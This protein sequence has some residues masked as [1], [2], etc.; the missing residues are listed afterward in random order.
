MRHEAASSYD[1]R[2]E[3][4]AYYYIHGNVPAIKNTYESVS[5]KN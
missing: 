2:N 1:R 3:S 4:K 5:G